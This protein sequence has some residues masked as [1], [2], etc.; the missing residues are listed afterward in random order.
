MGGAGG[1]GG[2]MGGAA[3][4][5]GIGGPGGAGGEAQ[6]EYEAQVAQYEAKGLPPPP[7]PPGLSMP[8][9]DPGWFLYLIHPYITRHGAIL[10]SRIEHLFYQATQMKNHIS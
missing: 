1:G 5:P 6:A 8:K 7:P 2:G 9:L 4:G 3:G 10:P